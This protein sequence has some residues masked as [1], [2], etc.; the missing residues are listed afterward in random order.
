MRTFTDTVLSV[1]DTISG[2]LG[3]VTTLIET[4]V[5]RIAP[6]TTAQACS[7]LPCVDYCQGVCNHFGERYHTTYYATTVANCNSGHYNCNTSTC[8]C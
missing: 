4:V 7:G 5:E 1:T 3:F 2:K 6:Q 8:S